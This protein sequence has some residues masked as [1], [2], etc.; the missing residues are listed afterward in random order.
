L[1]GTSEQH[2]STFENGQ[3]G[4][5]WSMSPGGVVEDVI[6]G[7]QWC[8]DVDRGGSNPQV[9]CV[10]SIVKRMSGAA[11]NESQL[12]G[13]SQRPITHRHDGRHL[14]R[15]LES[16]APRHTPSSDERTV[17]KLAHRD[18]SQEHL[19]ASHQSNLGLEPL[20]ASPA[21]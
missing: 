11:A 10:G 1:E 6:D 19:V 13:C 21:E 4:Y 15:F 12:G 20:A 5:A 8:P 18:R 2:T 16:L 7:Q 3:Y 17:A 9:V 14:D